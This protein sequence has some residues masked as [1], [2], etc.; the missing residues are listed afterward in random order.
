MEITLDKNTMIVT[1]TD[2][3]GLITYSNQDFCNIC[4]YSKDEL[5]GEAHNIVRHSDMPKVAFK[6]LWDTIKSGQVWSGVV[7]N[8]AKNGGYYWV[9]ATVYPSFDANGNKRYISVRVRATK[10]EIQEAEALY[11]TLH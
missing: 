7:K 8:Q 3:R 2:E 6:M 1:E 5:I 9:R 11:K 4:K 10:E